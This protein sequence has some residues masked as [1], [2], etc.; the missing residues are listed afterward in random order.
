[1]G[2]HQ[3]GTATLPKLQKHLLELLDRMGVQTHQR[4]VQHNDFWLRQKGTAD[5]HLLLHSLAQFSAQFLLFVVQ[6]H[7][8][9][10]RIG[11]LFPTIYFVCPRDKF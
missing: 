6:L 9:Q 3:N 8:L 5:T 7:A 11:L 2:A 10:Q 4:F 1:M